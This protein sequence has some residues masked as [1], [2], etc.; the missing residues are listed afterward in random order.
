[1]PEYRK[2]RV[3]KK[4]IWSSDRG[5]TREKKQLHAEMRHYLKVALHRMLLVCSN[6]KGCNGAHIREMKNACQI[7][8]EKPEGKSPLGRPRHSSENNEMNLEVAV[9]EA[10]RLVSSD[11]GE[12]LIT[13][14]CQYGNDH[15]SSKVGVEFLD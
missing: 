14:C 5:E 6:K 1:M 11:S 8:V 13:G 12:V 2:L 4:G 15:F 3:K 10:A 9:C 7:L